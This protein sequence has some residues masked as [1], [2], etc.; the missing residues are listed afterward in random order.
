MT[1]LRAGPVKRHEEESQTCGVSPLGAHGALTHQIQ[2][3]LWCRKLNT[4][5]LCGKIY[6]LILFNMQSS[7]SIVNVCVNK[8]LTSISAVLE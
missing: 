6:Y 8:L 7:D 4:S 2:M 3:A 1:A 5:V